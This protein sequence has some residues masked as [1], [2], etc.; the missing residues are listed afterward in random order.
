MVFEVFLCFALDKTLGNV[1]AMGKEEQAWVS[2]TRARSGSYFWD[3]LEI[4][5]IS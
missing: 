4:L 3:K 5:R 2:E 1:V